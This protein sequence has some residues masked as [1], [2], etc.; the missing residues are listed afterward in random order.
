MFENVYFS[1][2]DADAEDG[3]GSENAEQAEDEVSVCFPIT[4]QFFPQIYRLFV[5]CYDIS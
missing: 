2:H 5:M 4:C 1:K 3:G